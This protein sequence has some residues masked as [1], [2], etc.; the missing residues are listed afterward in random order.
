MADG[1]AGQT[2]AQEDLCKTL[3]EVDPDLDP[4]LLLELAAMV[5]PA[6]LEAGRRAAEDRRRPPDMPGYGFSGKTG[7]VDVCRVKW[8][9]ARHQGPSG[10]S[11]DQQPP[12]QKEEPSHL[13]CL[14]WIIAK[15]LCSQLLEI[16]TNCRGGTAA[17]WRHHRCLHR[18]LSSGPATNEA[19]AT[20][21]MSTW[22]GYWNC[23]RKGLFV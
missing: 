14:K 20:L 22:H 11:W 23:C 2:S 17:F 1:G 5:S 15:E 10:G 4:D 12:P 9:R 8:P 18:L 13:G 21:A 3:A 16:R 6:A 19:A 7:E